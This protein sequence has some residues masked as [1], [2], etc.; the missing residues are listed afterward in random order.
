MSIQYLADLMGVSQQAV[1]RYNKVLESM[2]VIYIYH[3]PKKKDNFTKNYYGRF[4]NANEIRL[5]AAGSANN[6]RSLAAKYNKLR[7]GY[8][9]YSREEVDEIM[10]YV[11]S[12]D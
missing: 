12:R 11:S 10:A 9:G 2:R 1:I 7:D 3:A 8:T 6:R 5:A 4:G